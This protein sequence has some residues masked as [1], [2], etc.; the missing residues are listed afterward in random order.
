MA[1]ERTVDP[2][3]ADDAQAILSAVLDSSVSDLAG[4]IDDSNLTEPY[5]YI[6]WS[7]GAR[8]TKLG[9]ET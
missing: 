5:S 9:T 6:Q 1:R 7:A 4:L 8:F 2:D 3:T